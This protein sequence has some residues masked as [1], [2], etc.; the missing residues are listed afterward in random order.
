MHDMSGGAGGRQPTSLLAVGDALVAQIP[1]LLISVAA[2]MVVSR[3]GKE[4]DIGTQIGGQVFDSPQRAGRGRRRGRRCWAWCRACRTWSSCIV[5]AGLGAAGLAA[6]RAS[7]AA[8]PRSPNARRRRRRQPANAEASWDDLHAGRHAGPGGGLPPDRA[9]G[10]G[11]PGRP[12]RAH[13]GRAQEVR[14]G[15]G[16]PAAA[17]AHPRQPG[18][19]QAQHVPR[20]AARRGGGRGR[21]HARAVAGHQPRRR[22]AAAARR[23][24]HRPG[25]RPARGVDRGAPQGD[26]PNGR[27]YGR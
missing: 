11:A 24:D 16:L 23:H 12:A 14:A 3:V 22:D 21:G 8:P 6:E 5:G 9:G 2:A 10:Q 1:A 25:F 15:R 17:G 7:A 13:Q 4:Q 26:G 19:A 27:I 20:H 18:R